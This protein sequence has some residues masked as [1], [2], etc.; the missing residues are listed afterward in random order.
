MLKLLR[1]FFFNI[2]ELWTIIILEKHSIFKKKCENEGMNVAW[3]ERA[4]T[5]IEVGL[6]PNPMK[7]SRNQD[8]T[9]KD[10]LEKRMKRGRGQGHRGAKMA[11]NNT[12]PSRSQ[13]HGELTNS[14]QSY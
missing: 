9:E 4:A 11:T 8:Y 14:Q 5:S 13:H 7:R 6:P 10:T 12:S 2:D 3:T 1:N